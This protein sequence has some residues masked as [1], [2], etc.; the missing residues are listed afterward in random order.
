MNV[1]RLYIASIYICYISKLDGYDFF[2]EG[3]FLKNAIV[4]HDDEKYIDLLSG[5]KYKIGLDN[6]YVGQMYVNLKR[7]LIPIFDYYDLEFKKDNM[8]KRRIL[9]I[10]SKAELLNKKEDDK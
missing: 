9:K 1:H 7:G 8:S 3:K 10:I 2:K 4:Y 6:S 5:E